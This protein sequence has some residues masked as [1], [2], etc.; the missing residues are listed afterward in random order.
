MT[1]NEAINYLGSS[2]MTDE[3]IKTVSA[4]FHGTNQTQYDELWNERDKYRKIVE[5]LKSTGYKFGRMTPEEIY[6]DMEEVTL[7]EIA[8][9]LYEFT[10]LLCDIWEV[11]T[12][13]ET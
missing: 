6:K 13:E 9:E 10:D 4:A 12:N 3:Q 11:I 1:R 5:I 7:G 8:A 2:G